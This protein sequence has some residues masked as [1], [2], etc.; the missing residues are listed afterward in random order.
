MNPKFAVLQILALVP[1]SLAQPQQKGVVAWLR[2][3]Q[4]GTLN[5]A[6]HMARDVIAVKQ[7]FTA[8]EKRDPKKRP[9]S[10]GSG[11]NNNNNN[12]S[13]QDDDD[14]VDDSGAGR[15]DIS[16]ILSVSLGIMAVAAVFD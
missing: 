3:V 16:M 9:S 13:T 1:T 15:A 7:D 2:D 14:D 11:S 5:S 12:N 4:D 8:A 6:S 10:S